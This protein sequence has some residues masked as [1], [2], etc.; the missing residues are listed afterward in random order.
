MGG[1]QWTRHSATR[2]G[3]GTRRLTFHCMGRRLRLCMKAPTTDLKTVNGMPRRPALRIASFSAVVSDGSCASAASCPSMLSLRS[4]SASGCVISFRRRFATWKYGG[5]MGIVRPSGRWYDA[6]ISRVPNSAAAARYAHMALNMNVGS[7]ARILDSSIGSLLSA[8]TTRSKG[9]RMMRRDMEPLLSTHAATS[10][11]AM[12]PGASI[13]TVI[14]VLNLRA[15]DS[16][17]CEMSDC[18]SVCGTAK[19]DLTS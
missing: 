6:Q 8:A 17:S 7:S 14:A 9:H 5:R 15:M 10:L 18:R 19:S 11:P 13:V 4:A 16:G 12:M 2:G 1:M 3:T